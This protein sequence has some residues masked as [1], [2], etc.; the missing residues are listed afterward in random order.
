MSVK[1]TLGSDPEFFAI[2]DRYAYAGC[3]LIPGSKGDPYPVNGGAVQV[4]GLALEINV[5]PAHSREE[6]VFNTR[7][8]MKELKSM[9]SQ[10]G[11]YD[12]GIMPIAYFSPDIMKAVSKMF[13]DSVLLGCD[14]DFNA[15][16][17]QKNSSPSDVLDT[18]KDA[19]LRT[20]AGHIHIGWTEKAEISPESEHFML[21]V[22]LA[23]E[24]DCHLALPSILINP[25]DEKKRRSMYGKAGAFRPKPYGMEYRA[26]SNFWTRSES[27]MGWVYDGVESALDCLTSGEEKH[28]KFGAE[29]QDV[30]NRG[31]TSRAKDMLQSLDVDTIGE[32]M[33]A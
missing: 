30:I 22:D 28:S 13:P 5:D 16:S 1:F 7:I 14:P 3:G 15:W 20:A 21:C 25:K 17:T 9:I 26:L 23:K 12:L 6:F 19:F 33:N 29:V 18:H 31:I 8:V 4:D 24:L 11:G 27:L 10:K 32:Y 2:K